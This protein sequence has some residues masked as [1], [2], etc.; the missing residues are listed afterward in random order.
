MKT[1]KI[2]KT[3]P[4]KSEIRERARMKLENFQ[5]MARTRANQKIKSQ[6]QEL[7]VYQSAQVVCCYIS[8]FFEVDTKE[9]IERELFLKQKTILVPR[10]L[11][12]YLELVEIKNWQVISPET[13]GILEPSEG[14][15]W[16]VKNVDL[17]I[18][19]GL[20]FTVK[21]ERLGRGRGYYDRL[22]QNVSAKKIGLGY[23]FQ[24]VDHF[25]SEAHD[26]KMDYVVTEKRVIRI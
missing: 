11:G 17:F 7:P 18:I 21:G 26:V 22:L 25:P 4:R 24:L 23:D 19:P 5:G 9:I 12:H 8:Q 3:K 15:V 16:D 14:K 10:I 1:P 6:L 13:Y 20:S 2:I